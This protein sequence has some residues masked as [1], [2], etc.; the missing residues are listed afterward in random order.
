MRRKG[1]AVLLTL[2]LALWGCAKSGGPAEQVTED[3]DEWNCM[4]MGNKICGDIE[5]EAHALQVTL[6]DDWQCWAE[7]DEVICKGYD[8]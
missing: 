2:S 4:T 8:Q 7:T 6:G 1:T 3:S 5:A